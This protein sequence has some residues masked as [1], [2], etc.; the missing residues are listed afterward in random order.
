MYAQCPDC[1]TFFHLK[2]AH[3]SAAGGN[4]RCSQCKHVFNALDSLRDEVTEEEIAAAEEARAHRKQA[5]QPGKDTR[6]AGDL[7]AQLDYT[8]NEELPLAEEREP[9]AADIPDADDT[10]SDAELAGVTE[11]DEIEPEVEEPAFREPIDFSAPIKTRPRHWS[12]T[13]GLVLANLLLVMVLAAQLL[14]WKRFEVLADPRA[15][16]IEPW[17]R[18]AYAELGLSLSP[19]RSLAA[20]KLDRSEVTSAGA[21]NDALRLTAVVENRG[22]RA[23]PWP[24]IRID[25]EN[26]WGESVG[27]RYFTPEEYL[28]EPAAAAGLMPTRQRFAI[29]LVLQDPGKDAVGF[30]TRACFRLADSRGDAYACQGR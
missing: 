1:L 6:A 2:P 13:L 8:E 10:V 19:P 29:E 18:L 30:Q 21:S 12:A 22:R 9:V 20:I 4:V 23:Q 3:L 11:A 26:R 5:S 7:F 14:H 25:L 24:D 28:R 27:A 16:V 15:A 17:M